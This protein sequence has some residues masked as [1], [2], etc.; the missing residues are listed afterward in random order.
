MVF[1]KRKSFLIFSLIAGSGIIILLLWNT[2]SSN[3]SRKRTK[4][5]IAYIGR[6]TNIKD[7]I[8]LD[9]QN[10]NDF[11]LLNE[12]CLTDYM[13][14]LNDSLS[15]IELELLTFD[16]HSNGESSDSIY[17]QKI[18][19]RKDILFV[20][21]NTWGSHIGKCSQTIK[22]NNIPVIA[23]NA[24]KNATDFGGASLFTGND[25]NVPFDMAA[26][27]KKVLKKKEVNFIS[28]TDYAL[29]KEFLKALEN[30]SIKVHNVFEMDSKKNYS[31]KQIDSVLQPVKDFYRNHTNKEK[32]ILVINAHRKLGT[33]IIQM[34]EKELKGITMIGGP[35][36]ITSVESLNDFGKHSS[37]EL[38]LMTPPNDALSKKLYNYIEEFKSKAGEHKDRFEK[39]AQAPLYIKRCLNVMEITKAMIM[40]QK[41]TSSI[42][43]ENAYTY[44]SSLKDKT[45]QGEYDLYKF[46]SSKILIKETF[47][48]KYKKGKLYSV[49][50]Q[51]NQ[52]KDI[53][54]NIF[55]G[56]DIVDIYDIDV[57]Q[58]SFSADF[59]YWVK[60]D[61]AFKK[62]EE[63]IIF[64]N[65][66]Q[67]ESGKELILEKAD[68]DI[69]YKL[70]KVSGRFYNVYEL[71]EYPLDHQ[72]LQI[73]VEIL[74]PNDKLKISFD[75]HSLDA[76]QKL[77]DRFKIPAWDKKRYY[78]TVD[79]R[80]TSTMRGD[81]E[82]EEGKATIFK[83]FHFRLDVERKFI[84]PFL[85]IILPLSLIGFV[86][87]SVLYVKD[88]SF[89]NLGEVSVGT[90]LGIITFSI[91]MSY[92]TP[93]ADYLTKADLFFW[94]TFVV[95][96]T[97]FM[98][99]IV[100]NA[101]YKSEI[102]K[103]VNINWVKFGIGFL[104]PIIAISIFVF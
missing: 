2:L 58:S 32:P 96:L 20:I 19:G 84:N 43:Q 54:P 61:T 41:D 100:V 75:Q 46:D 103:D 65:I 66:K 36:I 44:F 14:E 77:L 55:F 97:C 80:I 62:V 76:D 83:S 48:S 59:F 5:Y 82:N 73:K 104:Y 63:N 34:A 92:I 6:Y 74:K 22:T 42:S 91:A 17:Q 81:P 72:E 95:V 88:I 85:E 21:D 45:I 16:N 56:I 28:E 52:E 99:I 31:E 53:I 23:M 13:Q 60:L 101:K 26:F 68:E 51:L 35:F 3:E 4:K 33:R 87:I 47:F 70:Y 89:E 10:K 50:I 69:I 24:D 30:D 12:L 1:F 93:S 79:N 78:F 18:K 67:N 9:K 98:T 64:H 27:L 102:A 29:H 94:L 90:F 25:D 86:A 40:D 57:S 39:I 8:P 38:Y 11:D 49:P 71:K 7:T 15:Q 37:N